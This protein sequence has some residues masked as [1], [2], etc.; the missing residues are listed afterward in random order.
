MNS[1]LALPLVS[2]LLLAAPALGQELRILGEHAT[3]G[4]RAGVSFRG[5]LTIGNLATYASVRTYA[6]GRR[7]SSSGGVALVR[8]DL[9]LTGLRGA[10]LTFKRA[11]TKDRVRWEHRSG[12]LRIQFEMGPKESRAAL[13]SRTL[14]RDG[15]LTFLTQNN[16]GLVDERAGLEIRR[17]RQPGPKD[18]LAFKQKGGRTILSLNGDQRRDVNYTPPGGKRGKVNLQEF[19]RAQGLKHTW[20]GM[21]ASRAPSTKELVAVFR[22][23]LDDAQR[24]VL[25]HCRGGADRTGVIGALYQIEFLG[26]SKKAAKAAMRKHMWMASRGTEIQGAYIDLFQKGSLRK[27]LERAGV[28]IPARYRVKPARRWFVGGPEPR[29][30]GRG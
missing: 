27:L 5:T 25:L 29:G 21:S 19:I 12:D 11:D 3:Q 18:V 13:L 20:V 1:T 8:R 30:A 23:L 22:V 9:V 7:E 10:T 24:P 4:S 26:V 28:K 6:D 15:A 2:V 14:G 16:R 17:S